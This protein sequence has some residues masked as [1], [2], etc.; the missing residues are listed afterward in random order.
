MRLRRMRAILSGCL[1]SNRADKIAAGTISPSDVRVLRLSPLSAEADGVVIKQG[2]APV[3]V[4]GDE[5]SKVWVTSC[6]SLMPRAYELLR[7]C[8]GII[9]PIS[10]P[11]FRDVNAGLVAL[12]ADLDQAF[13]S[14]SINLAASPV[15]SRRLKNANR[16][17]STSEADSGGAR[18]A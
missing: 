10:A 2:G 12:L 16:N 17:M 15:P 13:A 3:A 7:R 1:V 4:V 9:A 14:S 8:H 11:T 6:M 5:A 18:G